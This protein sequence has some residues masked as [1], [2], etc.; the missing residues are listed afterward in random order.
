M[1]SHPNS[2]S[3]DNSNIQSESPASHSQV[4][5]AGEL[6]RSG[7]L[8][9][10]QFVDAV[11]LCKQHVEPAHT[12]RQLVQQGLL[13]SFQASQILLGQGH[14]LALDQYRVL[15]PLSDGGVGRVYLGYDTQNRQKVAIKMLRESRRNNPRAVQRFRVEAHALLSLQHKNLLHGLAY[16]K[17]DPQ[18][19]HPAYLVT[20]FVEGP[21]LRE[22]L[23]IRRQL[24]WEVVCDMIAQAASGLQHAHDNRFVHR[25]IKPSNLMA[26]ASGRVLVIDFGMVRYCGD[27]PD[28]F[29][30]PP[31]KLGFADY[32]APEQLADREHVDGRADIYSL[33]CTMFYLLT[34]RAPIKFAPRNAPPPSLCQH[35]SDA[36]PELEQVVHRMLAAEPEDRYQSMEEVHA[37]LQP[38]ARRAS[39][40]IDYPALLRARAA[41]VRAAE[42]TAPEI[43]QITTPTVRRPAD[44][45]APGAVPAR[46]EQPAADEVPSLADSPLQRLERL[47]TDLSQ[48]LIDSQQALAIAEAKIAN[49]ARLAAEQL[50][51]WRAEK[52][53]LLKQ[54][55]ASETAR[56]EAEQQRQTLLEQI[57]KTTD[58]AV[59]MADAVAALEHQLAE[60]SEDLST[61]KKAYD[62]A[63]ES[64]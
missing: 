59:A 16:E 62:D 4:E 15:R 33:G 7:L 47:V 14:W 32:L 64:T 29:S 48:R 40:I 46:T 2:S 31:V 5:F 20:D 44:Q 54:L 6:K 26:L 51:A 25:D 28:W 30:P 17:V 18:R 12:A 39:L 60:Q 19:R 42:P 8:T 63:Q 41:T 13:T 53:D 43:R 3:A 11:T 45:T 56:R 1:V 49:D 9:H 27:D 36:P 10:G 22:L 38:L 37:E 21:N 58:H 50:A 35:R 24:P 55:E 23:A 34:G 52:E 61:L 57:D